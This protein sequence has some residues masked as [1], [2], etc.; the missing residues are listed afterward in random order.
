MYRLFKR[1]RKEVTVNPV[2]EKIAGSI[3]H[4]VTQFQLSWAN[5]MQRKTER[6]SIRTKKY[7]V[8]FLSTAACIYSLYLIAASITAK[9]QK[10]ITI[11][12][13]HMPQHMIETGD[14]K[15]PEHAL[16]P[17]REY[18]KIIRFQHYMDS[19]NQTISG[20][21]TADSINKIRPGLM[22]STMELKKL[23]ELQHKIKN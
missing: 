8:I 19:L 21:K 3:V 17:E 1:K 13:I 18:I 20:K 9:S 5:F 2:Q 14:L 6:F 15:K 4:K 23:Y 16:I 22:D 10:T 12:K 7:T 11:S